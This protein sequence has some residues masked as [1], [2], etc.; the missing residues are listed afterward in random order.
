MDARIGLVAEPYFQL[1]LSD[2]CTRRLFCRLGAHTLPIE[3]GR[4]I[5]MAL[6]ARVCPLC[7]GMHVDDERHCVLERPASGDICQGFRMTIMAPCVFSC[8][9]HS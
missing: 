4:R 9:T 2:K 8:G 7:P 3:M 5:R 1:P 6:V